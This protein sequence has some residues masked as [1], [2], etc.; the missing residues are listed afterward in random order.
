MSSFSVK[1]PVQQ[2]TVKG[3]SVFG[4]FPSPERLLKGLIPLKEC[5]MFYC[6]NAASHFMLAQLTK[7]SSVMMEHKL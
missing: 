7:S 6:H 4:Q 3:S 5:L 2:F 1:L